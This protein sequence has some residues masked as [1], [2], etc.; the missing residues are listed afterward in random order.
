MG[1]HSLPRWSANRTAQVVANVIDADS[2]CHMKPIPGL[3]AY[4]LMFAHVCR[5]D[6]HA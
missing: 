5:V 2:R 3:G 4:R 6:I 1:Y